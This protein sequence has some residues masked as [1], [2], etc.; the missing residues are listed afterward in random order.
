MP[1]N[2]FWGYARPKAAGQALTLR[3]LQPPSDAPFVAMKI[4]STPLRAMSS[5]P[6]LES[7]ASV[8]ES[9]RLDGGHTG[10]ARVG[11]DIQDRLP[12]LKPLIRASVTVPCAG[13]MQSPDH[14]RKLSPGF[15]WGSCSRILHRSSDDGRVVNDA[16]DLTSGL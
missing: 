1:P 2:V 10:I 6:D 13:S 14:V 9:V 7:A 12:K 16:V 4:R 11:R 3:M 8:D 15:R 5:I